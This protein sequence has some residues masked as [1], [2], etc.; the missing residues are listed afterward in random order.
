M[1]DLVLPDRGAVSVVVPTRG[2]PQLLGPLVGALA[3]D[4]QVREIVVVVDGEDGA[5]MDVLGALASSP[6]HRN[7]VVL[8]PPHQGQLGALDHGVEHAQ[9]E[10][11]LLLD[12]DVLPGPMLATGHARYHR[13]RTGLVVMGSMPV[14]RSAS[15]RDPVGT[16]LYAEEY[17]DHCAQIAQGEIDVLDGLWVGNL[18]VRRADCRRVGLRSPEY[19]V[20]YHSDRDLGYRFADAGLIGVY[21]PELGA[22]HLHRRGAGAFLRD[23]QRQGAGQVA[24]A[25]VH[26]GRPN[27][28]PPA[29]PDGG[30]MALAWAA[31]RGVGATKAAQ[32]VARVLM[33]AGAI[34]DRLG[35]RGVEEAAARVGRRLMLRRGSVA[36]EP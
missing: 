15:G 19:P 31:V 25:Q 28:R 27:P 12:D 10:V 5:S 13:Q 36:G 2:R 6:R 35:A 24:L 3:D 8:N 17:L 1:S 18:S 7:L 26:P 33:G 9:G 22:V 21:A 29:P 30:A 14:Q 11:I 4:P 34:A 16:R 23:A 32:P 20:F